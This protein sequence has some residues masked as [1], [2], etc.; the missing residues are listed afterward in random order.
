MNRFLSILKNLLGWPLSLVALLFILKFLFS[1]SSIILP[2]ISHIDASL[3]VLSIFCFFITYFLRSYVWWKYLKIVGHGI[4]FRK[5]V[6]LWEFSELKR[7]VPGNIWSFL[8]RTYLFENVG[9]SKRV[10]AKGLAYEIGLVILSTATLSIFSIPLIGNYLGINALILSS[11]FIPILSSAII[12]F[13]FAN[14]ISLLVKFFPKISVRQ[15]LEFLILYIIAFSFFGAGTFFAASSVI[16]LNN[17]Q[18]IELVGFFSFALLAGYLSFITPSGFGVREGII[19]FGLAK[20]L[21]LTSAGI[22]AIFTR[23]IL[24]LSEVIFALLVYFLA[25]SLKEFGKGAWK[26]IKIHR[27]ELALLTLF[28]IYI[29]YFTAA[30]FTKFDNYNM[31][32]FDLGNMDQ[33]VWNTFHGRFFQMTH[34]DGVENLSRLSFHA[35]FILILLAPFYAIWENPKTLLFIQTLVIAFGGIFVYFLSWEILK[36]KGISLVFAF[37]FFL[38][39]AVNYVNLFDFHGVAF[40]ITFFLAAFYFLLKRN[41][42]PMTILLFLAGITKEEVWIVVS[43]F[44]VLLFIRK[45]RLLGIAIFLS[46]ILIFYTLIWYAIPQAYGKA[47]FALS[48]YSDYG[49]SPSEIIKGIFLSPGLTLSKILAPD[50]LDYIKKLFLPLSYFSFLSPL[51]LI[52]AVPDLLINLLSSFKYQHQIYF[53]YSSVVTPFIFISAIFAAKSI[54]KIIHE[55]SFT[56]ISLLLITTT[57]ISAYSFGPVFFAKTAQIQMFTEPRI[58]RKA[59]DSYISKIPNNKIVSATNNLGSH[60]SERENIYVIPNGMEQSD[61][62]LFLVGKNSGG[63]INSPDA[64]LLRIRSSDKFNQTFKYENFYV[65]EKN[66]Q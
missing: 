43:L 23:I 61:L 38:N 19:T 5:S 39:P 20:T 46:S 9:I 3:L 6:Y 47:H 60:L 24:I 53:Q 8:G 58:E 33:T 2:K 17:L 64:A 32:R 62:V 27:Y 45:E 30:S 25:N 35:D 28:L 10:T 15:N 49:S 12:I 54:K 31:G 52:F 14:K 11:V 7:F 41:F 44:G 34:P 26:F 51:S 36:N 40:S 13:V 1:K 56:E 55:V 21:S 63:S 66:K 57:L 50:R 65:F 48:Y 59:I 22:I 42:V 29:V 16:S 4:D 18:F 37:L